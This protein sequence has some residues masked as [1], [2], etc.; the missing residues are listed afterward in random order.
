MI[1]AAAEHIV[2]VMNLPSI[3]SI[4]AQ[5]VRWDLAEEN[6]LPPFVNYKLNVLQR[7]SK[8]GLFLYAVE[9]YIY[10]NTILQ[11][12]EI[13]DEI[14]QAVDES[15]YNWKFRT[16]DSGYNYTDGREALSTLTFEFKFKA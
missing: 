15:N 14:T 3:Q 9:L 16:A 5:I 6:M 1:K 4:D 7:I 13:A 8:D 2:E 11:T 12:A 10:G